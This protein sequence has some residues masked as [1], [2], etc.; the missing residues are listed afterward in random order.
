A[1]SSWYVWGALGMYPE[2]PGRAELALGSPLF[3]HIVVK[4]ENGKTIAID[5]PNASATSYYVQSL[6]VNGAA[7][8]KP[9]L[10]ESFVATGGTLAYTIAGTPNPSWGA[11]AA[12]AP[13]S[14]RD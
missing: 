8:T 12:D 3:P 7:S 6:K 9:W 10:P 13:P 14:F 2:A 1:T 5:A 4:R 11:A